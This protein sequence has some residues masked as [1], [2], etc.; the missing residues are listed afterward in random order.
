MVKDNRFIKTKFK[1][2]M[3]I[4][5]LRIDTF[6]QHGD[7]EIKNRT[8]KSD[9]HAHFTYISPT[10]IW[11]HI[12]R[13]SYRKIKYIFEISKTILSSFSELSEFIVSKVVPFMRSGSRTPRIIKSLLYN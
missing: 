5:I 8:P 3:Q 9:K 6:E 10:I 4:K 7:C 1:Y 12:N 2:C 11:A 13:A